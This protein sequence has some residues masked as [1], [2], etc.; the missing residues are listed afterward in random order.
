MILLLVPA[1]AQPTIANVLRKEI[2]SLS[3]DEFYEWSTALHKF[4]DN[5]IPDFMFPNLQTIT[6]F[7]A[8]ATLN[9]TYDQAH[10]GANFIPLHALLIRAFEMG[11]QYWYP[12]ASSIYWDWSN[13]PS[14]IFTPELMGEYDESTGVILNG[15]FANYPVGY[16]A[17][18][19]NE[20]FLGWV[21]ENQTVLRVE[22]L[23]LNTE[24]VGRIA[25][26]TMYFDPPATAKMVEACGDTTSFRDFWCCVFYD[27]DAR[28]S[29]NSTN[30]TSESRL[31][32]QVHG[33]YS[34][35]ATV[36]D[37]LVR[38]DGADLA[39]S[40]NDPVFYL[41][42]S[43]IERIWQAWAF[44]TGRFV[45]T[46]ADPCGGYDEETP[47]GHGIR[48]PFYP[49][50]DMVDAATNEIL[51]DG[52]DGIPDTPYVVCR[53]LYANPPYEYDTYPF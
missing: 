14:A 52:A 12:N 53:A 37:S 48:E 50:I 39:T 9:E 32:G 25:N 6:A 49:K 20:D 28:D 22:S 27:E 13:D 7:H 4:R 34:G 29:C 3:T 26:Q 47:E 19:A 31:H 43:N 41:H 8:A 18:V 45:A 35:Y 33:W 30:D 51:P 44:K 2:R 15:A 24:I 21:P 40:P 5:K 46:I 11:L 38:F 16:V 10:K 1:L 42:H 17:D 23:S 36:G